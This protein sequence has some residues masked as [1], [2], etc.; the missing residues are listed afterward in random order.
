MYWTHIERKL[1]VA[2]RF[3]KTLKV[4]IYKQITDHNNNFYLGY[5][6]KLVDEYNNT[7]H[8]IYH[9]SIEKNS[10]DDYYFASN[11]KTETNPKRRKHKVGDRTRITRY[12]NIFRKCWTKKYHEKYL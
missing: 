5:L 12:N 3:I 8:N 7:Y 11:E 4:K 2:K 9:R 6:N 1:V 10:I